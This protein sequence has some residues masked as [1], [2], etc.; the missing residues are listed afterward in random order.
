MD[1]ILGTCKYV[2]LQSKRDFEDM[3]KFKHVEK[4]GVAWIIQVGAI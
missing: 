1:L 2:S 4:G 3:I